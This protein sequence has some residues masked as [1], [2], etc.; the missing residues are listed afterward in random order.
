[1]MISENPGYHGLALT[2]ALSVLGQVTFPCWDLLS[3]QWNKTVQTKPEKGKNFLSKSDGFASQSDSTGLSWCWLAGT[4]PHPDPGKPRQWLH[5]PVPSQFLK[6]WPCSSLPNCLRFVR[7]IVGTFKRLK[8]GKTLILQIK[9]NG[10]NCIIS[11]WIPF[12]VAHFDMQ[13][14]NCHQPPKPAASSQSE[15]IMI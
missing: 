1:M 7:I 8:G 5:L 13:E 4:V 11:I 6:R 14:I 3:C 10:T 15:W 9:L 2:C 12:L